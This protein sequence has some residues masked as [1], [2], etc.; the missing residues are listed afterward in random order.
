M[1]NASDASQPATPPGGHAARSWWQNRY[2]FAAFFVVSLLVAWLLLRAFL[3]IQFGPAQAA[4]LRDTLEAFLIGTY[5]DL[6]I[7]LFFCLPLF[8]W[9]LLIRNRSFGKWWHRGLLW[10]G[11][12]LFWL[13]QVFL[14]FTEYYFFE[15]FRSR[16]NT[17]AVDYLLYP[18]EV[19][20]NIWDSYPVPAVLLA[21]ALVA[22]V[23]VIVAS[24]LF[25]GM[26]NHP[27]PL[28]RR[29]A[30]LGGLL[31]VLLIMGQAMFAEGTAF[32]QG[33]R[34]Q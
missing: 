24:K 20:V 14:F 28:K 22:V 17:V 6:Y 19:F 10:S 27:V 3:F 7:G 23:W 12:F 13:V 9:F 31:V 16:F 25:R 34:S 8:F 26:W 1:V 29:F 11:F 5:R 18:T 15:E 32:Q 21:C 4:S 30:W 2:G 33:A